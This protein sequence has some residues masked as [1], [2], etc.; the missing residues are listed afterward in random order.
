MM[1]EKRNVDVNPQ[2]NATQNVLTEQKWSYTNCINSVELL[3]FLG[4]DLR[5]SEEVP[6]LHFGAQ[7]FS[8]T[9]HACQLQHQ[10]PQWC[11]NLSERKA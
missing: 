5:D 8:E 11:S 3:T 4:H 2:V 6:L 7:I 10:N 1:V 9:N